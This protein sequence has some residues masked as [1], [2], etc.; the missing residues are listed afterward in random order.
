M[1]SGVCSTGCW[2]VVGVSELS[3][4]TTEKRGERYATLVA[5]VRYAAI[6]AEYFSSTN[7][8]TISFSL[9]AVIR[10]LILQCSKDCVAP[11]GK[12]SFQRHVHSNVR[13]RYAVRYANDKNGNLNFGS[14]ELPHFQLKNLANQTRI[15]S[16]RV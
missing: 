10:V 4:G 11:K 13:L 5:F 7:L 9:P 15:T 12:C 16:E 1:M 3:L 8:A 2:T 14:L 6:F